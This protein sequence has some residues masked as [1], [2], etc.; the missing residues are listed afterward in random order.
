MPVYDLDADHKAFVAMVDNLVPYIYDKELFGQMPNRLPRLTLG[1]LLMRQHRIGAL[2]HEMKP[3]QILAFDDAIVRLEKIRYEWLN[4]YKDKLLQEFQSR[5]NALTFFV[6]DCEQSW[7]SCDANWPN[8][9]EKR[10][11]VA[12]LAQEATLQGIFEIEQR[13]I[14]NKLDQKLRRFSRE[15]EF[16]WDNRLKDA[17]PMPNYWWLHGRPGRQDTQD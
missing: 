3:E 5:V 10:T 1:G 14:L 13:A 8:E 11:I 6:E 2:R 12:H 7:Q 17:Y 15:S 9:A 4:H 16:L